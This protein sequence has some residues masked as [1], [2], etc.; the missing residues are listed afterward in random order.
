MLLPLIACGGQPATTSGGE[1]LRLSDLSGV[2][3]NG[4]VTLRI[5]DAGDF[6]VQPADSAEQALMAGFV[7]RDDRHF[8]FVTGVDG[9]CPGVAGAYGADVNDDELTLTME[10]DTC[11]ERVSWFEAAFTRVDG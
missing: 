5:N 11:R 2:W 8:I 7:A 3:A 9:E 4:T 10:E 6:L 1:D